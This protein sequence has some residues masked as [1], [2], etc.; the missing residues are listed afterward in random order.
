MSQELESHRR[1]EAE[2]DG[3]RYQPILA[4]KYHWSAWTDPQKRL[5]GHDL[6]K[7]LTDDLFPYLRELKGKAARLRERE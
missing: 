3:K 4:A 5:S 1:A 2:F 7:F 6:L